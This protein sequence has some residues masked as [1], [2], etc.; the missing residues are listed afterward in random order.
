MRCSPTVLSRSTLNVLAVC[1]AAFVAA[2]ANAAD[3][4]TPSDV[5]VTSAGPNDIEVKWK[6]NS[7]SEDAFIIDRGD[8]SGSFN[9]RVEV[10]P[11]TMIFHDKDVVPG[12]AYFYQ[13]TARAGTNLSKPSKT[14]RVATSGD[15][16]LTTPKD[17]AKEQPLRPTLR[18]E[19]S[20]G[21]TGY[22]V[23]VTD[24]KDHEIPTTSVPAGTT[25]LQLPTGALKQG[26]KLTWDVFALQP[27]G[28]LEA[29]NG[30][31][32]FS[33]LTQ[34]GLF[35]RLQQDYHL[36]LQRAFSVSSTQK[37]LADEA[38]DDNPS[39]G[40]Q[41]AY[42]ATL[43]RTRRDSGRE[44]T[45][46]SYLTEINAAL[47]YWAPPLA[48]PIPLGKDDELEISWLA[49]A[50]AR[51]ATSGDN[52]TAGDAIRFRLGLTLDTLPTDVPHVPGGV[53]EPDAGAG[54]HPLSQRLVDSTFTL[55]GFKFEA[56]RNFVTKQVMLEVL[57]APTKRNWGIGKYKAVP[58]MP[59]D[60]KYAIQP[61]VGFD[62]GQ[63]LATRDADEHEGS[64]FRGVARLEA[65][66][67]FQP[68][69]RRTGLGFYDISLYADDTMRYVTNATE[70]FHNYLDSGLQFM[71]NKNF[72]LTLSYKIGEDSPKFLKEE[73]FNIAF[74]AQF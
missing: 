50:E 37:I 59:Q 44:I 34:P 28:P 36:S 38:P 13:V 70:D 71:F 46:H 30:P 3:L 4:A 18:W 10:P 14:A 54:T 41:V 33:T 68:W 66:L 32:T 72:G 56:D 40:A 49:S 31:A 26:E 11:N 55:V 57:F 67:S 25:Q 60:A 24:E 19:P 63:T 58:F 51:V 17:K 22:K 27:A 6:D 7:P 52:A 39:D 69:V 53:S 29:S 43:Q 8:E 12:K 9:H 64:L 21:A 45:E 47:T 73:T 35:T 42:T 23:K 15:F 48:K 65:H 16:K 1:A 62:W 2:S 61:Y 74:T 5:S 20:A